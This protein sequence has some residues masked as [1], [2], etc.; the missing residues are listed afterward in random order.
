MGEQNKKARSG[1]QN[2]AGEDNGVCGGKEAT[3]HGAAG[4]LTA[5]NGGARQGP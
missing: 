4:K 3:G 1:E 5:A 2:E